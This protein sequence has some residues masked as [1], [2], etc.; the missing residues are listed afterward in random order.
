V[1]LVVLAACASGEERGQGGQDTAAT[2]AASRPVAAPA[3]VEAIPVNN[4]THGMRATVR[5]LLSPDRR[6]MIVVEDAVSVE[7]DALPDGFLYA[8]EATGAV[9]QI[10]NVWDVAP[11]PD[12]TRLAFGRAFILRA[13]ERDTVPASEWQRVEAQLPED[14]AMR[15]S[16]SLRRALG[17][18]AFPV[19]GMSVMLGLGLAQV[20]WVDTLT[21]GRVRVPRA[22]THSLNGWRVRWTRGGDTRG[23]G[24]APRAVQDDAPP[25]HWTLVRPRPWALFS[26][27]LGATRDSTA[28]APVAWIEGP[29]MEL[30]TALEPAAGQPI[31]VDGGTID[32]RDGTIRLTT[33]GPDGRPR[34]RVVG[35]GIPLAATRA[36]RFIAAVVPRP[37]GAPGDM[38]AQTVVYQIV[39]E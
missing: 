20:M 17:A 1:A 14:V 36:G 38:Q 3:R 30:G 5:W 26:D 22:P 39:P 19:S 7:A 31:P 23:G 33:R 11:S 2:A 37:G 8:S 12:W 32:G 24:A 9:V 34:V 29:T 28:F 6:A 21:A 25:S 15:E 27:T 18:H 35:P 10:D 4:G 13:G 16:R